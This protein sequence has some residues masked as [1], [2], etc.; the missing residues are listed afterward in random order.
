MPVEQG[1]DQ[2]NGRKCAM[3]FISAA[4]GAKVKKQL[5]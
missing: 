2:V 5:V 3:L 4:G 1:G